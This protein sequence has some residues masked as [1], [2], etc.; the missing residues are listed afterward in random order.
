MSAIFVDELLEDCAAKTSTVVLSALQAVNP[1]IQGVYFKCG[2]PLE[3]IAELQAMSKA[4]DKKGQRYPLI[5]LFR[6]FPED[7]GVDAGIYSV[8]RLNLF[9]IALTNPT[10]TT[11]QRKQ[12]NFKP[13]LY[14]I[15]EEF[16]NQIK[17]SAKFSPGKIGVYSYTQ[18]D[19]Y[20][21]GRESIY[22]A[23]ANIF[24][25]WIDCIEL[26]NFKL[27]IYL[28]TCSAGNGI[29]G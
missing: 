12:K 29:I 1:D 11:D 18:I 24:T 28:N 16:F 7:R 23:E 22:G 20:F 6:D 21:W 10:F 19:H 8:P 13:I 15:M 25:D 14:P 5:A 26:K 4:A 3:I 9:F 17:G 2:H 27:P